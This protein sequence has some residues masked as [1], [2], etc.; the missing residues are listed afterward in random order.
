MPCKAHHCWHLSVADTAQSVHPSGHPISHSTH[1]GFSAP[2]GGITPCAGSVS[3]PRRC[4]SFIEPFQSVEQGVGIVSLSLSAIDSG[5]ITACPSITAALLSLGP[6]CFASCACG[7][8]Q[9]FAAA[10]SPLRGFVRS[11]LPR[12]P[13]SFARGV[14]QVV[15]ALT[16][17]ISVPPSDPLRGVMRPPLVPSVAVG[18]G[19]AFTAVWSPHVEYFA[20]L[21]SPASIPSG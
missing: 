17:S 6:F 18:V 3:C 19:H 10:A 13:P 4:P 11:K 16:A 15:R 7:V 20:I 1:V 9:S 21:R 5:N 2:P 12:F 8:G 14:G